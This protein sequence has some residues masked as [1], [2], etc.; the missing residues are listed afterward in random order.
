MSKKVYVALRALPWARLN[1]AIGKTPDGK[2]HTVQASGDDN[3]AGFLP[4]YWSKEA[5]EAANPGSEIQEGVVAE[6]WGKG[7]KPQGEQGFLFFGEDTEK[8]SKKQLVDLARV[9]EDRINLNLVV[10][11]RERALGGKAPSARFGE[12][13][14]RNYLTELRQASQTQP[15]AGK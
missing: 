10:M 13:K 1:V 15:P 12:D 8:M 9:A 3:N 4:V 11:A 5:A 14:L 6:D 2:V 7:N